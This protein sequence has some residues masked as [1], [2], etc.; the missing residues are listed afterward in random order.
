MNYTNF[1]CII[2][3]TNIFWYFHY[4]HCLQVGL[5]RFGLEVSAQFWPKNQHWSQR[6]L[7]LNQFFMHDILHQNASYFSF[8]IPAILFITSLTQVC[9]ITIDFLIMN[10][11]HRKLKALFLIQMTYTKNIFTT[12][13]L[14]TSFQ[15][16]KM[17]LFLFSD[18]LADTTPPSC[19]TPCLFFY[20]PIQ[21]MIFLRIFVDKIY[22]HF[23]NICH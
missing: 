17:I 4:T 13:Q 3:Y 6:F 14:Y 12:S 16:S 11:N 9:V 22:H 23:F 18:L 15:L 7:E 1:P 10:V 20:I 5:T 8:Y 21:Q 2:L 19:W